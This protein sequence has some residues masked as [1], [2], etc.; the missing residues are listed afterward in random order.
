MNRRTFVTAALAA[1]VGSS[2]RAAGSKPRPRIVLRSSWQTVNIGDIGH[3]PGVLALL[4]QH[5]PEAEVILWPSTVADGVEEMLR[6]RFPRLVITKDRAIIN[7]GDFLLHGSGPYL[8]AHR[9]LDDWRKNVRKPYGVYGITMA[10]AGDPGLRIMRN[11]GLDEPTRDLLN[12]ASFVFFRDSVS[13]RVA[14]QGGVTAPVVDFGPDGAF[15]ADVRHEA[16][17]IAFLRAHSLE[18][19]K[20]LCCIPNLRNA[21]YWRIKPGYAFDEAKHRRNEAMQEHDH[22]PLREAISAVVRGTDLKILVCPEDATQMATGKE[23]LV[24]P[25]PADVKARVVWREKFWLTDEALS[26]YVRS[27][28]LFGNEMHSPIM[29]V[30]NGVPAI[31]CRFAEQTTKGFMWRDI[32]LGDW[33]FDLDQPAERARIAATVLTLAKDPAA[34]RAKTATARALVRERQAATMAVLRQCLGLP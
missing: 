17:A 2:P 34:A 29:C 26:T 33:L 28:G 1:A 5:L 18:E 31:V 11:N 24:D 4:E 32:G 15:A 3:S 13:L 10:A 30:G 16:A 27:A 21:P 12:G 20:F 8:T 6:H 19:G 22:A 7:T 23:L 25:L 9:D 14:R